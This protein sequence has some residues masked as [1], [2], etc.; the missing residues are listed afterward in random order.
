MK[1][2]INFKLDK[3]ADV[4]N[5]F[6]WDYRFCS[7]KIKFSDDV[8][9]NYFGDILGYFHD[10]LDIAFKTGEP[11]KNFV[12]KFSDSISF[13]QAIYIQQ[14]F[15]E[16]MLEIFNTGIDKGKLKKDP[17]YLINRELR[18]ELVGH[19][20]RKNGGKLIS[21]TLFSYQESENEIQYLRYHVDNNF[22]FESV[23][24]SISGIQERHKEFLEKYFEIILEKLRTVLEEFMTELSKLENVI[25][26]RDFKT[27][28][29]LVELFFEAIFKTDYAYD[30]ESLLKIFERKDEH[31]RYKNFIDR[32]YNDLRTAIAEKKKSVLEIYERKKIDHSEL[33]E[34]TVRKI[35]IVFSDSSNI[36]I[37][38]QPKEQT[39]HYEIEKIASKRNSMDFGF[40]SRLLKSK[41]KDN[42]LVLGELNHME[43]N[44]GNDI[45]YYTS[46]RLI[47]SELN[48]E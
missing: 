33:N 27:V 31:K 23:S 47:R 4:W 43:K 25:E 17:T 3:I 11:P 46:L 20:I 21:S 6:I 24:Y 29:K 9:T 40:F 16:E 5:Y 36:E 28:L 44:I 35:E 30:K 10:T 22:K 15:V 1:T 34:K 12:D 2:D 18:N 42:E 45:E 37:A 38:K 26:N 8:K 48:S 32:F 39:Y 14:D 41:C 13:L 19:P 7:R